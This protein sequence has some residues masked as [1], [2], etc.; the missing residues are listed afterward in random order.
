VIPKSEKV[1]SGYGCRV[2][3]G[4]IENAIA[5]QW[6]P[7]DLSEAFAGRFEATCLVYRNADCPCGILR[8]YEFLIT[9]VFWKKQAKGRSLVNPQFNSGD[10]IIAV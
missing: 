5:C 2:L 10:R 6:F 4:S 7:I 8:V 3:N 9:S 1:P